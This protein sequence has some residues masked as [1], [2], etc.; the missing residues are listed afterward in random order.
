MRGNPRLGQTG[1][2]GKFGHGKLFMLEQGK[3]PDPCWVGEDFEALRP[4]VK[5][6]GIYPY[7]RI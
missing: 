5:I 4:G 3:E 7:I 2:G 1:Y 6:H